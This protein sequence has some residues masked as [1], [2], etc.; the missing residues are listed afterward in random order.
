MPSFAPTPLFPIQEAANSASSLPRL[1]KESGD[2]NINDKD[3]EFNFNSNLNNIYEENKLIFLI[4]NYKKSELE[5]KVELKTLY[6]IIEKFDPVYNNYY[7]SSLDDITNEMVKERKEKNKIVLEIVNSLII[8]HNEL[9]N[10]LNS[11]NYDSLLLN[12]STWGVNINK[13]YSNYIKFYKLDINQP[14]TEIKIR[15]RP[16]IRIRYLNN[17]IKSLK[18][19]LIQLKEKPYSGQ[20]LSNFEII[21]YKLSKCLEEARIL[22]ELERKKCESFVH[23]YNAKDLITLRSVSS[24]LNQQDFNSKFYNCSLHYI[25]TLQKTAL[26]FLNIEVIFLENNFGN[27]IAIIQKD[28]SG[29]NLLFSPIRQSELRFLKFNYSSNGKS[30]LFNHSVLKNDIQLCF[31]FNELN[32]SDFEK[33][34]INLF[35]N[36]NTPIIYRKS[37]SGLNIKISD[38]IPEKKESTIIPISNKNELIINDKEN[39]LK[40]PPRKS[41]PLSSYPAK[42]NLNINNQK[43]IKESISSSS[44]I[45]NNDKSKQNKISKNNLLEIKNKEESSDDDDYMISPTEELH[46]LPIEKVPSLSKEEIK[47]QPPMESIKFKEEPIF[48]KEEEKPIIPNETIEPIE[49]KKRTINLLKY[50]NSLQSFPNVKE[51]KKSKHQSIFGSISNFLNKKSNKKSTIIQQTIEKKNSNNI[52][53]EVSPTKSLHSIT[54]VVK[55]NN[56]PLLNSIIKDSNFVCKPVANAKISLWTRQNWTKSKN[57]KL[58]LHIN[59]NDNKFYLGAYE[60]EEE[61]EKYEQEISNGELSSSF[62]STNKINKLPILL[63]KLTSETDC[64]FNTI[65]IHVKTR[66]YKNNLLMVLIRPIDSNGM[67]LISNAL[68]CPEAIDL[69]MNS[70]SYDS[71]LSKNSQYS[72]ESL[73]N[74]S[75]SSIE[76]GV[77]EIEISNNNEINNNEINNNESIEVEKI[78]EIEEKNWS[79]MG[80]IKLIESNGKLK[81]LNRCVFNV[82]K[83]MKNEIIIDLIG[84]EFGNIELKINQENLK[85]LSD[86]ELMIKGKDS[87]IL[88]FDS[89][90][91]VELFC[92]CIY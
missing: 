86:L 24:S 4:E 91:D 41:K 17:F 31:T 82:N 22:D 65:D 25:N 8:K 37:T 56:D 28:S 80:N 14:K 73:R 9:L 46:I 59:T 69:I 39:I 78:E 15:R 90:E 85:E 68:I 5:Y 57:V 40:I 34:M 7:D 42:Q 36:I 54:S 53:R 1:Q 64:T 75:I 2:N 45:V 19:I 84:F 44:S 6:S 12:L 87:Y 58:I 72:E 16:L 26:N 76:S 47:I 10:L 79:G 49:S 77:N 70:E 83:K 35:P 66:N 38:S 89:N 60:E 92:E 50:Q 29:K 81:D 23:I 74:E 11:T 55:N 48:E 13:I 27:S 61:E 21:I 33:K 20:L 32:Q 67:K 51:Q 18:N 88:T 43:Q 52:N 30:L 63:L 62:I 3:M 71:E